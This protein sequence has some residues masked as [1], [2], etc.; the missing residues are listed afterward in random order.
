VHVIITN[1]STVVGKINTVKYSVPYTCMP[2]ENW[3]FFTFW[4]YT[5]I[6]KSCQA[7][8]DNDINC[9]YALINGYTNAVFQSEKWTPKKE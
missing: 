8:V 5:R 7:K 9:E 6:H 1:T 2:N 3:Q 4:K